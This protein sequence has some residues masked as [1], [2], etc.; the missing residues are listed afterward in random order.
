VWLAARGG[1]DPSLLD[2]AELDRVAER[3]RSYGQ[4]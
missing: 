2:A 1:G 3:L 4:P